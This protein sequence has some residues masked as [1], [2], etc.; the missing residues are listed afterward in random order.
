MEVTYRP[1]SPEDKSP[2]IEVFMRVHPSIFR[3]NDRLVYKA[4]INEILCS[5]NAYGLVAVS[6]GEL[7]GFITAAINWPRFKKIFILKHPFIGFLILLQNISTVIHAV[8][9]RR[10]GN[11]PISPSSDLLL[12]QNKEEGGSKEGIAYIIQSGVDPAHRS[13]GIGTGLHAS[14]QKY[15]AMEGIKRIECHIDEGNIASVIMHERT[16]WTMFKNPTG[17]FGYVH[18]DNEMVDGSS[19]L[20]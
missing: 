7:A 13:K 11:K 4:F 17:Y 12:H 15:L 20:D 6:N 8:L 16:H 10:F 5:K 1:I 3:L 14:M 19:L 18:L 9:E 2:L